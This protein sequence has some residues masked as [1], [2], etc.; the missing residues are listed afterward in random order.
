MDIFKALSRGQSTWRLLTW[1]LCLTLFVTYWT[2]VCGNTETTNST[3]YLTVCM[4][5]TYNV[6]ELF[7]FRKQFV[8]RNTKIHDN[9]W[10]IIHEAEIAKPRR[11]TRGGIRKTKPLSSTAPTVKTENQLT[12]CVVNVQSAKNK[13]LKICDFI[14]DNDLDLCLMTETWIQDCDAVTIQDLS[15]PGYDFKYVPRAGRRGGG[16]GLS[17]SSTDQL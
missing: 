6:A 16:V 15:P 14:L 9:A 1:P 5:H 8:A 12:V 7:N 17:A 10:N 3:S 4:G 11:G 2:V 13:T